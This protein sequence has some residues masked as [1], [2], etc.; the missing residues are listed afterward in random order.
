[1]PEFVADEIVTAAKMNKIFKP[2]E[3]KATGNRTAFTNT[4]FADLDALTGGAGTL[5]AVIATV[6]TEDEAL[7]TLNAERLYSS[8]SVVLV[9]YRIS[10]ATTVASADTDKTLIVQGTAPVSASVTRLVT[11]LTPGTN[12]FEVQARV[13]SGSGNLF[14]P[15]IVVVPI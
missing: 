8:G 9:S 5:T 2:V 1:M 7:V 10:G 14:V 13:N 12:V 11:G 15:S 3:A 6:V 4:S